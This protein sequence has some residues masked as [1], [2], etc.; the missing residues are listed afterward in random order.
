MFFLL[1]SRMFFLF[2]SLFLWVYFDMQRKNVIE[3]VIYILK[4]HQIASDAINIFENRTQFNCVRKAHIF[5]QQAK[6]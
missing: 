6:R 1:R 4:F 5:T 2:G 3:F